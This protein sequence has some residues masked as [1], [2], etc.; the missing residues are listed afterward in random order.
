[1]TSRALIGLLVFASLLT[2]ES[3]LA[4]PSEVGDTSNATGPSELAPFIQVAAGSA[5]TCAVTS[6]G[7]AKCW[8]ANFGGQL[9]DGTSE[10]RSAPTDVIG[11]SIYATAVT[12]GFAHTCALTTGGGVKCWGYGYSGQLGDGTAADRN[13]PVDVSGM[14]SNVV[15]LVAGQYHTCALTSTGGVKCWGSNSSGQ[16]GDGTTTQRNAP[17]DVVG[18]T[19]GVAAL[20]A[21]SSHTCARMSVGGVK[22][23]GSNSSG[24]LGDGTTSQRLAPAD[25][26]GLTSG[27]TG[28][29]A[30]GLHSCASITSGG[31]KCWGWNYYGQL[32]DGTTT[33]QL[34]PVSVVGITS[35]VT[36]LVAGQGHTCALS[37]L[38]DLVCWGDNVYGQLGDGT[39]ALQRLTPVAVVG[40]SEGVTYLASGWSHTCSLSGGGAMKCWGDD[41]HGQLGLGTMIRRSTPSTAIQFGATATA[42]A[43]GNNHTCALTNSGDAKCW[44]DNR[45]G[46]VGDGSFGQR[47]MPTTVSGLGSGNTA[48]VAGAWH[49]C[50]LTSSSGV[51][52]WG[53]NSLG[54]LGDGSLLPKNVPVDTSGL[55]NGVVALAAGYGHTCALML[56]G[57][58]KCWGMNSYG[59]IGDGTTTQKNTPVD[60]S[61][62]SGNVIALATGQFHTCA[63]IVGGAV[64]CWGMNSY[65]QIGDGTWTQRNTPTLVSGLSAGVIAMTA[66]DN[67]NCARTT[68]D[69]VCWGQ[70]WFGQLGNGTRTTNSLPGIASALPS[71]ITALTAGYGHTCALV[72]SGAI[73]WGL[74]DSGELGDGS[75]VQRSIPQAVE[76]LAGGVVAIQAG[77]YQTCALLSSGRPT[78]WG[79]DSS[80]Q[81]GLG[82]IVR[83]STPTNIVGSAP[84]RVT[85]NYANGSPGSLFTLT[86]ENYPPGSPMTVTVNSVVLTTTFRTNET[87]GF[88]FFI[89]TS[90]A[91]VGDY[92]V[93]VSVNPQSSAMFTLESGAPIRP[94]EG[95]GQTVTVPAGIAVQFRH[96]YLPAILR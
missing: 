92:V 55:S 72:N 95:G 8:G 27:V 45:Y 61:G 71:G 44:G 19:S 53:M 1:M 33:Q 54:Q 56:G 88:I 65:G 78:C 21:G 9:G 51:K 43:V 37:I 11:L 49:S 73:C 14:A 28:L 35:S 87:G 4:R 3:T 79:S 57:G 80:G 59:Q 63:L 68:A 47:S 36:M 81:L 30:G 39:I 82:T 23:W 58:V 13:S 18:L 66:G 25:V 77:W 2:P 96:A 91:L 62:L 84:A 15:A 7:A 85:L 93:T 67:H 83:R 34:S 5:H 16:L 94:P 20:A 26:L 12:A 38:G 76:G 42:L 17:V 75:W 6:G 46:Q 74:N 52:C 40:H 22:C 50:A 89:D 24:Q 41:G 60:V 90:S 31:V 29:G 86:G 64:K 70:N 32:G 69:I 10:W 48:L